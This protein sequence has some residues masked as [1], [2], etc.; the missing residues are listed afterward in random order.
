LAEKR[1]TGGLNG[2]EQK[3]GEEHKVAPGRAAF[4]LRG[5]RGRGHGLQRCELQTQETVSPALVGTVSGFAAWMDFCVVAMPRI[6]TD[7][8]NKLNPFIRP[9]HSAVVGLI[10]EWGDSRE[11]WDSLQ[12]NAASW[13]SESMQANQRKRS[14]RCTSQ[15]DARLQTKETSFEERRQDAQNAH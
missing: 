7:K 14:M 1:W 10:A 9:I 15:S 4:I 2:Q 6:T 8:V 5:A 11:R 12:G 13:I 3:A